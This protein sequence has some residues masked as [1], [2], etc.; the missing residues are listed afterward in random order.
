MYQEVTEFFRKSNEFSDFL[1]EVCSKNY[2]SLLLIDQL[3][4]HRF[5]NKKI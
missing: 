3:Q 1:N 4:T 2:S 5:L